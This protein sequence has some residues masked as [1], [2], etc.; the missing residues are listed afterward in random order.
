MSDGAVRKVRVPLMSH[1]HEVGSLRI[2]CRIGHERWKDFALLIDRRGDPDLEPG[3]E[4]VQLLEDGEY[5]FDIEV[6]GHDDIVVEPVDRF[7]PDSTPVRSG[8]LR[9]GRHTGTMEIK[10]WSADGDI[11]GSASIEVR[12]RKLRYLTE[13]RWMLNRIADESAELAMR[14]FAASQQSFQPDATGTAETIYQQ[15][16]FVRSLL[17]SDE[18]NDAMQLILHRPHHEYRSV[19]QDV[20]PARGIRGGR[21]LAA[22]IARPGPRVEAPPSLRVSTL[23][24]SIQQA[25]HVETLDTIPNQFIRYALRHWQSVIQS[26]RRQLEGKDGVVARRGVRE[27]VALE[28]RLAQWLMHPMVAGASDLV[29]FP[30]SN[31]VLQKREGYRDVFQAFVLSEVAAALQWDGGEHVFGAG[32]RDVA[33]LYEY[34]IF[35]EL[36]RVV[37]TMVDTPLDRTALVK[38]SS[39]GMSLELRQGG[40]AVIR[41]RTVRR[42]RPLKLELWFNRSFR[43]GGRSWSQT[44]RPDCSLLVTPSGGITD[45]TTW[46]H[47][48]A[49]YRV[50]DLQDII[51]V[52]ADEATE[53]TEA[54]TGKVALPEDLLKMHAYRDAIRRS[55][56]A[57]VLYPGTDDAASQELPKYHEVVP[58][59]GAF[60]MRPTSNGEAAV[61]GASAL[62]EFLDNVLDHCASQG[63]SRERARFWE[64]ESYQ[65]WE[66]APP[67]QRLAF[68]PLLEAPPADTKV[69]L[70]FVRSQDHLDWIKSTG[71]YNLRADD[72]QGSVGIDSPELGAS[73]VVLYGQGIGSPLMYRAAGAILV[74]AG[75]ELA[76][77]GYPEPRGKLYVCLE[78]GAAVDQDDCPVD[79]EQAMALA[80]S[81]VAADELGRPVVVEWGQLMAHAV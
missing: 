65:G 63:T 30:A 57:Y 15:F 76:E 10:V 66:G 64:H 69:L 48:D 79:A 13:Y 70:G 27:A 26:V 31:Q 71:L 7:D 16:A 28:E 23:P 74:K 80:R 45:Q 1:G 4:P 59:I 73:L 14:R 50:K 54:G 61:M 18:L 24:E 41:G 55:A 40:A 72:R 53:D 8:R 52:A 81:G 58:G 49:K 37:A 2:A 67:E 9:P 33:T 12:A 38:T 32:L 75:A 47:F 20:D 6:P 19:S 60:V 44:M 25:S 29:R 11:V 43:G 42:G 46:L 56:G 35:L 51:K 22:A 34:W 3:V 62:R 77:L 68:S 17:D 39:S 5:V 21:H 36:A 78:L